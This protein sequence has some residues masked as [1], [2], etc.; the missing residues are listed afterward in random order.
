MIF[1]ICYQVL[2]RRFYHGDKFLSHYYEGQVQITRANGVVKQ[3]REGFLRLTHIL[4]VNM[5][6]FLTVSSVVRE[7]GILF[8][9]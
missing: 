3:I 2:H 6:M 7:G 1:K 9:E 5:S 4:H 8:V